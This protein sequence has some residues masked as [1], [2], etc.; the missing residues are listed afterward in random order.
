[1]NELPPSI[2]WFAITAFLA[3]TFGL[4]FS[5]IRT[6]GFTAYVDELQD[7][8]LLPRKTAYDQ[9]SFIFWFDLFVFVVSSIAAT[10]FLSTSVINLLNPHL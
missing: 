10:I 2:I 6:I 4:H 8:Q 9:A 7:K 1:M 3:I 5:H